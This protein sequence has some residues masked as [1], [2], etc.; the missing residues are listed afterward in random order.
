MG[1]SAAQSPAAALP[2][3]RHNF[4]VGMKQ[5]AIAWMMGPGHGSPRCAEKHFQSLNWDVCTA[6][7]QKWWKNR[8]KILSCVDREPKWALLSTEQERI[9]ADV[10][11]RRA[12]KVRVS[13]KWIVRAVRQMFPDKAHRKF[14]ASKTWLVGF[15][16]RHGL[17]LV[18]SNAVM[19]KEVK[20]KIMVRARRSR[21]NHAKDLQR[22]GLG[23]DE[24]AVAEAED[25]AINAGGDGERD[26]ESRNGDNDYADDDD[27]LDEDEEEEEEE[28][29]DDSDED[30]VATSRQSRTS[31]I[32]A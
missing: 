27:Y 15:T 32:A 18:G 23:E 13:S 25:S 21:R 17:V 1:D 11:R 2:K 30:W 28:D 5:Q 16:K 14:S 20:L 4:S 3:L 10:I 19:P 29:D 26:K 31:T 8:A 7:L 24:N 9:L 6:T 22:E 12:M